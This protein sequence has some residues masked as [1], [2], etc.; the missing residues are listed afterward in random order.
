[1]VAWPSEPDRTVLQAAVTAMMAPEPE[2]LFMSNEHLEDLYRAT[3]EDMQ[4]AIGLLVLPD[5]G[6]APYIH[7]HC[8]NWTRGMLEV[9]RESFTDS[10]IL[11]NGKRNHGKHDLVLGTCEQIALQARESGHTFVLRAPAW[12]ARLAVVDETAV[13]QFEAKRA[14]CGSF[15]V[16]VQTPEWEFLTTV[17]DPRGTTVTGRIQRRIM[18]MPS[19]CPSGTVCQNSEGKL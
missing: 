10:L 19:T 13:D 8:R 4:F 16:L 15:V 9:V 7:I 1:M 11:V 14:R 18:P 2:T 6:T 3:V 12:D 17:Y 5:G